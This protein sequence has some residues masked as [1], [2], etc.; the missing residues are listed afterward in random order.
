MFSNFTQKVMWHLRQLANLP[1]LARFCAHNRKV[2]GTGSKTFGDSP[3]MLMELN[4]MHSAHI[5]YA[6][7]AEVM[8]K[9]SGVQIKAYSPT[10]LKSPV[11]AFGF[12]LMAFL[13]LGYF[14]V[15][16]SFGV[17]DFF[18]ID[19]SSSQ[20]QEAARLFAE[21]VSNVAS[22]QDVEDL[23][24]DGVWI[25]DLVYDTYLRRYSLPTIDPASQHF[26]DFLLKSIELFVFW[27][28]YLSKHDVRAI[29]VSH[30]V[31]NLAMPLRIGVQRGIDVFQVNVTH[32]YRLSKSNLFAYNDFLN[33]RE[34][35]AELPEDVRKIGLNLAEQRILKRFSGEVG[36][37][38]SYSTE[39]AYGDCRHDRLL[40]E[41]DKKKILIA[42]HC[43]FDSPHSY[44]KNLFPDF[45]EWLDFLGE[46]GRQTDYDWYLKIHPDYK[47]GTKE[48]VVDFVSRFPKISMLPS[49]ASHL[50]II[51]EGIDV[52]LTCY[53]T[54]GFEYAALG[55]PVINA[56]M[57]NPHIAYNFNIHARDID[58]YRELLENLNELELDIDK[59]EVYEY[60]FMKNIFNT[61]NLFCEDYNDFINK[62]G[63]YWAQFSPVAY[64]RW[65]AEWSPEK[66]ERIQA[67]LHAFIESKDFRMDYRHFGQEFTLKH[68]EKFV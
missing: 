10:R 5:A 2:R 14:G 27:N 43:F 66:H 13:G 37:D 47:P 28:D 63:G 31:Y 57:T 46:L 33:F 6:Y 24:I 54:I 1:V 44:G 20:R 60:Y 55:V 3:I 52:A 50:Q 18:R 58:H 64:Q 7:L 53:G 17:S 4:Y 21:V 35:F 48:I 45:Y 62:I 40:R 22:K 39:S 26:Q 12:D 9:S 67:A 38:M 32:V 56:S 36:V 23:E 15:Y 41:S 51:D 68:L 8:A 29:S 30:C 65:L 61:E 19:L 16:R 42:T 25:G 34:R 11:R 49:D 59:K